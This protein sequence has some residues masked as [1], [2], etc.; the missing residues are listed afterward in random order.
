MTWRNTT[1]DVAR[2]QVLANPQ[3][4]LAPLFL[5]ETLPADLTPDWQ[6]WWSA[7]VAFRPGGAAPR[8]E[9]L[10]A[11][12]PELGQRWRHAQPGFEPWLAGQPTELRPAIEQQRLD[13]FAART[14]EAPAPRTLTVLV[15]PFGDELILRPEPDR[16]VVDAALR[17]DDVRYASLLDA[18]FADFF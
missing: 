1:G 14:G 9:D 11:F 6:R 10:V 3:W 8:P 12:S 17:Q 15:V 4:L 2:V 13:S 5:R 7:A 16:L 18:V